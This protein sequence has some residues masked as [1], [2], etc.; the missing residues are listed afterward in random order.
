[1]EPSTNA[2]PIV[3][4]DLLAAAAADLAA[5]DNAAAAAAGVVSTE[6]AT[7]AATAGDDAKDLIE[8]AFS[9]FEPIYPSLAKVYKPE[10]RARLAA[11]AAPLL[12]KYNVNLGKLG[13]EIMFAVNV[14]PLIAPTIQAI[15]A[16]RAAVA[17]ETPAA[18]VVP[19]A[20]VEPQSPA[21][22][23]LSGFPGVAIGS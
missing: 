21:V 6:P 7:P 12:T 4:A 8:F 10:T 17:A 22:S 13:P 18:A 15:R 20:P 16:D 9:L 3:G 23:P 19:A 1:M 14:V 5:A 2:A 11:S